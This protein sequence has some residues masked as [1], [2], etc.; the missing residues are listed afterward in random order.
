MMPCS[1]E[2]AID[3]DF[4][5]ELL[6]VVQGAVDVAVEIAGDVEQ[7]GLALNGG[8]VGAAGEIEVAGRIFASARARGGR[9]GRGGYRARTARSGER[10]GACA[11]VR[12]KPSQVFVLV[13]QRLAGLATALADS[14]GELNHLIDRLLAV[15]AS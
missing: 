9:R 7:L 14:I 11:D 2:Y 4:L 5:G 1:C 3:H 10:G 6:V 13:G 8:E 12:F 15:Q